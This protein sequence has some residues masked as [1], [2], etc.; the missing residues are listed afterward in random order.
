MEFLDE[1]WAQ[2]TAPPLC[3]ACKRGVYI[4][5]RF[6][7]YSQLYHQNCFRCKQ[8]NS[9]LRGRSCQRSADGELFCETH[10]K[11]LPKEPSSFLFR[12]TQRVLTSG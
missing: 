10:Y 9:P 5:E 7:C 8:C 12:S 6:E 1:W 2:K 11:R 3:F 4:A